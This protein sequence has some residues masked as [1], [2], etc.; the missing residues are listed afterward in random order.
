MLGSCYL[1][2]FTLKKS[3]FKSIYLKY[4]SHTKH[5]IVNTSSHVS[6]RMTVRIIYL[7]EKKFEK[8]IDSEGS[9]G[10]LVTRLCKTL[11]SED[12]Q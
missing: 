1:E 5:Y 11:K 10:Q 2:G 12:A 4:G 3:I 7:L 6:T 9:L 8:C